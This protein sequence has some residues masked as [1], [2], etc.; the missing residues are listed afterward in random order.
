[1]VFGSPKKHVANSIKKIR[2]GQGNQKVVR[3]LNK[4]LTEHPELMEDV[5]YQMVGIIQTDKVK[6]FTY[7]IEVMLNIAEVEPDLLANSSDAIIRILEFPEDSLDI[8]YILKTLDILGMIASHYPELMQPSVKILL[9]KLNNSNSQIRSASFYILD[10]IAKPYPEYFLNH[11]LDLIRSLHGLHID[12]RLYAIR[13]TGDVASISPNLIDEFHEVLSDLAYKHPDITIRQEAYDLLKKFKVEDKVTTEEPEEEKLEFKKD[14]VS[15]VEIKTESSDFGEIADALAESIKDI[16]F[17]FEESA[18]EMLK[19]FGMEHLI[20]KPVNKV[21]EQKSKKNKSIEQKEPFLKKLPEKQ[22]IENQK[23]LEQTISRIDQNVKEPNSIP[24]ISVVKDIANKKEEKAQES[25]IF[26]KINA[27]IKE[28]LKRQPPPKT[29]IAVPEPIEETK[30]EIE[31]EIKPD[32]NIVDQ[33]PDITLDMINTIFEEFSN[34]DWLTNVGLTNK[35]GT[36]ITASKPD[37]IDLTALKKISDM[38]CFEKSSP[39]KEGFRNRISIELS[40]KLIVALSMDNEYNLTAFTAPDV[41]F[42]IVLYQLNKIA[43][44]LEQILQ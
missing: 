25:N 7:A 11:T 18:S 28:E 5:V 30:P 12:E 8:N 37:S 41:Q 26:Y 31:E 13:L 21:S 39:K 20:I 1:M 40:D 27:G 19:S 9:Q 35:D 43:D 34:E 10:L 29:G 17:D 6:N 2:K 36:L 16:D 22:V 23:T 32:E 33:I 15:L 3:S 4:T 42:V 38:L 14:F 24:R 44:K